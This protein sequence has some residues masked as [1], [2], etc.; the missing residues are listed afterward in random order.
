M[1]A[2][3]TVTVVSLKNVMKTNVKIHANLEN[4]ESMLSAK[5]SIMQPYV[6]VLLIILEI[7]KFC[8]ER[9]S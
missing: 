1:V 2:V 3:V 5:L 7:L 4:V 6:D 9:V 8:V